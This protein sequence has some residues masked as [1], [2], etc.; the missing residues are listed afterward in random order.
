VFRNVRENRPDLDVGAL[1]RTRALMNEAIRDVRVTGFEY[2]IDE[3][4]L[5]DPDDRHVLAAAIHSRAS[6]IVTVNLKDFST[7]DLV[8]HGVTA[9]HPD[10]FL[11]ARFDDNPVALVDAVRRMSIASRR[12]HLAAADIVDRLHASG[13]SMHA[14]RMR[15]TL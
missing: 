10:A 3:L 8:P 11:A 4:E 1:D 7:E 14:E 13:L 12:P 5:P 15:S 6:V 2:L 9:Q